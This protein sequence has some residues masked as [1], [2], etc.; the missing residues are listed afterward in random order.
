[1]VKKS[2]VIGVCAFMFSFNLAMPCICSSGD[3]PTINYIGS[4]TVGKFIKEASNVYSKALFTL[5]TKVESGG[6]ERGIAMGK[7]DI[8][9]VARDVGQQY[10]DKGVK[11]VLIGKDA[12]GVWVNK[13]NPVSDLETQQLKDIFTGEITNWK[14]VGGADLPITIYIVDINSATW[15][16]FTQKILEG[17]RYRGKVKLCR[18]DSKIVNK[19]AD[20]IGGI[21]HL[22]FALGDTHSM[23]DRVKKV[24][25]DGQPPTVNNPDY[26]ITRPLYLITKGEP[27]ET[28]KAFIGWAVSEEG[29]KIVK[30]FFVGI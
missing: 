11:P 17:K 19:V 10:I 30:K 3:V 22:S 18:P 2:V 13:M 24:S 26:P 1:M 29:Q 14:E 28:S 27:D 6:G 4:S 5:N 20:D 15:K 23:K 8:G 21:G 16:V 7:A 12:I 25:V 9:G